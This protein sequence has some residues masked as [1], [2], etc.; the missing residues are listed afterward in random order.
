MKKFIDQPSLHETSAK[1]PL[2][3]VTAAIAKDNEH[4]RE[5]SP[6]DVNKSKHERNIDAKTLRIVKED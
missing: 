2:E 6:R 3:K 5:L 1:D 4:Y